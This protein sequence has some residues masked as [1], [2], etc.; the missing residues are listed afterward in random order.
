MD[1]IEIYRVI[2][3]NSKIR[4]KTLILLL[5]KDE[6]SIKDKSEIRN[7]KS[8]I[9]MSQQNLGKL[10]TVYGIAPAFLQR[11]VIIAALS[12]IFFLVTLAMFSMWRNFLYFFLSTAFLLVYLAT[13]FGWLMMR[14]NLLRI[15][16]N[17][18]TYRKFTARWDEIASLETSRTDTKLNCEIRKTKGEKIALTESIHGVEEA[19]KIIEAKFKN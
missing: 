2:F 4:R 3:D 1:L 12:F 11:A 15:Y 6:I 7:H 8:E 13:M 9:V 18:L 16:E 14:K 5:S 17:G 19:I 10:V